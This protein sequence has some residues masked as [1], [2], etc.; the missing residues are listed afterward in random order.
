MQNAALDRSVAV[1]TAKNR[2]DQMSLYVMLCYVMLCYVM[3]C[4]AFDDE[5]ALSKRTLS[6]GTENPRD[7]K[8][9]GR[10]FFANFQ[11]G[12]V[13]KFVGIFFLENG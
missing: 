11:E 9:S 1:H 3:L 12:F 8:G 6:T 7:H 2:S 5:K 10:P 4:C 13:L